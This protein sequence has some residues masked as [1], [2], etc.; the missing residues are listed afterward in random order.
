MLG[1]SFHLMRNSSLTY[2]NL[3]TCH[4][5]TIALGIEYVLLTR[6]EQNPHTRLSTQNCARQKICKTKKKS[7]MDPSIFIVH[8]DY[9][10]YHDY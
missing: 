3:E 8:I 5:V 2:L 4:G 7:V 10:Q 6:N 1:C 9:S